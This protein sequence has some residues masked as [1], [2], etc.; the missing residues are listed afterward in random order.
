MPAMPAAVEPRARRPSPLAGAHRRRPAA[1]RAGTGWQAAFWRWSQLLAC[2][3]A[4]VFA[5]LLSNPR[6]LTGDWTGFLA[7]RVSV[8][9]LILVGIWLAAWSWLFTQFGLN[10]PTRSGQLRNEG[11]RLLAGCLAGALPL[12]VFV[13]QSRTGAFQLVTVPLFLGAVLCATTTTR[14]V[15]RGLDTVAP[16]RQTHRVLIVGSGP[17]AAELHDA[18]VRDADQG[19]VVVG[20][21]DSSEAPSRH[22]VVG[23]VLGSVAHLES[24]LMFAVVDEVLIALPVRSKYKEI[25][26]AIFACERVGVPVTYLADIFQH[27]MAQPRLDAKGA[28]PV[29]HAAAAAEDPRLVVKRLVDIVGSVAG[30]LVLSPVLAAAA[31]AVKLT[32]RGPVIF[33]QDRY[34][35]NKRL[36]RM[37]KFRT[38]VADAELL[39]TVLESKNEV[40][41]PVFKIASDPRVTRVGRVLRRTSIDEL[42]QLFNVL[43]GTMT[44]VGPRPLPTRDVQ[45]FSEPWLMRRFSVKPGCTGLWQISGR[46]R[47]GFDRWVAMDLQYID[48]WSLLLDLKILFRTLF[49]VLKQDGAV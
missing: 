3:A 13:L 37:Y 45:R 12:L 30:L 25:Q 9:N 23:K 6:E 21:V 14:L 20:F 46:N 28:F 27:S 43:L 15:L 11:L 19:T 4:L 31:V 35:Y 2:I 7:M 1:D 47:V 41:G 18:L 38:M 40:Q 5:F 17:R 32:S 36:F 48:E 16:S 33:A 26:E 42:P 8:R 10:Q 49:V 39:Q 24:L 29:I 44:L 22:D 34:G